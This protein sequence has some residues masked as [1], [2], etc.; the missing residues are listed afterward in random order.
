[1]KQQGQT[2]FFALTAL[3]I[4]IYMLAKGSLSKFIGAMRGTAVKPHQMTTEEKTEFDKTHHQETGP[5]E[6]NSAVKAI[7]I[8]Y[9]PGQQK[10]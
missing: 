10:R 1:M 2:E 9:S 8:S 7:R 6:E 3:L 5:L 4:V